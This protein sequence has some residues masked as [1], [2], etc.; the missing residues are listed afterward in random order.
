M[1]FVVR[2]LAEKAKEHNSEQYFVFVD[3]RKAYDS[4]PRT[5]LWITLQKLGVPVD[6]NLINL[7]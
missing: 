5:V 1:V 4:A 3:L 2:Q 6:F 7:I